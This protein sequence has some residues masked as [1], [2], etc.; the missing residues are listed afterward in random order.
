MADEWEQ[1]PLTRG[2]FNKF[3]TNDHAHLSD[4]VDSIMGKCSEMQGKLIVII[5]I[6]VA[7]MGGI[8]AMLIELSKKI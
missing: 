4:K 6:G 1:K 7:L 2:E 3:M 8:V 5:A